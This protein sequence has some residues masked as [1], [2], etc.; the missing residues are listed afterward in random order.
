MYMIAYHNYIPCVNY[1]CFQIMLTV[2]PGYWSDYKYLLCRLSGQ[3]LTLL[4]RLHL[5]IVAITVLGV[6]VLHGVVSFVFHYMPGYN[7]VSVCT[8]QVHITGLIHHLYI[9]KSGC[10]GVERLYIINV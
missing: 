2:K 7:S 1:V 6:Y 8:M 10:A 4:I 5:V 9:I 3:G